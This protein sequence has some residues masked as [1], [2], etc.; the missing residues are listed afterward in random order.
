M[1]KMLWCICSQLIEK[2][3]SLGYSE[4]RWLTKQLLT[5]LS[6]GNVILN[7]ENIDMKRGS[8]SLRPPPA[9][10]IAAKKPINNNMFGI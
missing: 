4:I 9:F 6:E 10:P 1:K 8:T 3:H 7:T 2:V 5:V